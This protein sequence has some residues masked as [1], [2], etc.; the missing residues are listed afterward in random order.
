L[1]PVIIRLLNVHDLSRELSIKFGVFD[2]IEGILKFT[3]RDQVILWNGLAVP[4]V[5]N[6]DICR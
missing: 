3:Q 2:Q 4:N 1:E 5:S 6:G